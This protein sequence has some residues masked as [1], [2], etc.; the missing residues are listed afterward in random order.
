MAMKTVRAYIKHQRDLYA[1]GVPAISDLYPCIQYIYIYIYIIIYICIG[2]NTARGL[3]Q[4]YKN[5]CTRA[6]PEGE[7]F[8][9][10]DITRVHV[11]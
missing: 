3:Y 11:L 5:R 6:K 4:I 10:S 2:Y 7:V 1:L 8:I 9:I